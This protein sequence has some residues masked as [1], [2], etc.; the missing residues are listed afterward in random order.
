VE[1]SR[2]FANVEF[3]V[4]CVD[5]KKGACGYPY[6]SKCNIS[7]PM[8]RVIILNFFRVSRYKWLDYYF[9]TFDNNILFIFFHLTIKLNT[10][11]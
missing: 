1:R 10:S 9:A 2:D 5:N 8:Q 11:L 4:L 7:Y 3:L 6:Y